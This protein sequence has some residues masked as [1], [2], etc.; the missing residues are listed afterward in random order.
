VSDR[1]ERLATNED[2][3]REPDESERAQQDAFDEGHT[4]EHG[5]ELGR[6]DWEDALARASS[7]VMA[8]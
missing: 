8:G 1:F 7:E 6:A 3:D 5:G 4:D 2:L